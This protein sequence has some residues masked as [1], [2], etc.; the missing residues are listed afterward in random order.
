MGAATGGIA[1]GNWLITQRI[2][3]TLKVLYVTR[4]REVAEG[5]VPDELPNRLGL[6]LKC[7]TADWLGGYTT[8]PTEPNPPHGILEGCYGIVCKFLWQLEHDSKTSIEQIL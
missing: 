4:C 2:G 6:A 5:Q 7:A 3:C 8:L 1:E